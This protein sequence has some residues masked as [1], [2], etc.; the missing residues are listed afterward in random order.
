VAT[1]TESVERVVLRVFKREIPSIHF[2][3]KSDAA[4]AEWTEDAA[5]AYRDL[6]HVP[7]EMFRGASLID[8]GAGTGE[9][10]VHFANW[11]AACTLVEMNED[12]LRIA[13]EVFRKYA[14]SPERHQLVHSSIFEYRDSKTYDFVC[15]RGSLHHTND[16]ERA[17]SIA[18]S[19]LRPGGYF[20]LGLSSPVGGFQNNLQR[21]ICYRF[22][23]NDEEIVQIAERLFKEDID[24][25]QEFSKRTR[26][27]IIFDRWVVPKQDD[28]TAEEVLRWFKANG[29]RFYHSHPAIVPPVQSDSTHHRP[30]FRVTD[31]Q[32]IGAWAEAF[33]LSHQDP[34][35][36]E[37]PAILEGLDEF[38]R[39]QAALTAHINDVAPGSSID[40]DA[41]ESK[42][43]DHLAALAGVDL[44]RFLRNRHRELFA[45]VGQVLDLMKSND[46]DALASYLGQT[47]HLFRGM[48]GLRSVYYVGWK[49]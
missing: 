9:N 1:P 20:I 19:F 48:N 23:R 37:V 18:A 35:A 27:A 43:D 42:I 11:G 22:G 15:A 24:R 2:S 5:Y 10:T 21:M 32:T 25:A 36:V 14:P 41:L 31:L 6:L 4:Y 16:K 40:L 39:R 3:D 30:H 46:L 26:R 45:E 8:F 7:P 49:G 28:P 38:A 29:L 12:A 13:T 47:K 33:W 44:T 34:D 17:F